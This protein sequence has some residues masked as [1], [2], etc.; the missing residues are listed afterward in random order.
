MKII[1]FNGHDYKWSEL[2]NNDIDIKATLEHSLKTMSPL[3]IV[4]ELAE[5]DGI[6][7]G[8]DITEDLYDCV[9]VSS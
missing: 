8:A 1:Y 5:A 4:N 6:L 7:P 9:L 3:I 2:A